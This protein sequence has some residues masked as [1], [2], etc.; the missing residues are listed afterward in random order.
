MGTKAKISPT[1][2]KYK[3]EE[4][5]H[6]YLKLRSSKNPIS[7]LSTKAKVEKFNNNLDIIYSS[8]GKAKNVTKKLN[9]KKS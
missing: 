2:F 6:D 4:Q 5:E 8:M 9:T 1:F 7:N 3:T